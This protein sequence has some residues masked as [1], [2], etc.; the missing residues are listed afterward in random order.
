MK[1]FILAILVCVSMC[2][3]VVG[4]GSEA[5]EET[6]SSERAASVSNSN[7]KEVFFRYCSRK[8]DS[9]L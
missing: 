6:S 3:G 1:R 5:V 9:F 4:C 8:D 7:L 2:I